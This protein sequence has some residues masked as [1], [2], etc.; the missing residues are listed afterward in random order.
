MN[1][2]DITRCV[3][4]QPTGERLKKVNFLGSKDMSKPLR[5]RL[6]LQAAT[7]IVMEPFHGKV[8]N[9]HHFMALFKELLE[10]NTDETFGVYFRGS[11]RTHRPLHQ[12][13]I[14]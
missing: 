13:A 5:R 4:S 3:P 8:L 12:I 9:H 6:Q 7:E 1:Q 14:Q 11:Q 10:S 2:A